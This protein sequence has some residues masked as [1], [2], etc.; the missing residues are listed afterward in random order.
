MSI[1]CSLK[2]LTLTYGHKRIFDSA[3][4]KIEHGEKIGLIGPNGCGKSSLL[5]I[6]SKKV[7]PD[8]ENSSFVFSQ[9]SSNQGRELE[10]SV[11]LIEQSFNNP[12]TPVSISDYFWYSYPEQ[13]LLVEDY[14]Y[15][16]SEKTLSQIENLRIWERQTEYESYLKY[17]GF[18]DLTMTTENLSGGE[19]KKIQLS[20]GL[21]SQSNLILWDEPTNHL[22]IQ[23]I[24]LLE[25]ELIRTKKTILIISHD[26]YLLSKVC[27]KILNI[28]NG[29]I[30][31]YNG[32][33]ADYLEFIGVKEE[34]RLKKLV[35]LKNTLRRE[36]EWM[37]QGIKARGTRSKK[38]VENFDNLSSKVQDLKNQAKKGLELDINKSHQKNKLLISGKNIEMSFGEK[39]LFHPF[40]FE[41]Y[42][43]EKIGLLGDNGVGKSTL[44][45]I[46]SGEIC[47]TNGDLKISDHLKIC[48]F[49]QRKE[50]I[51][52]QK[53]PLEI[54]GQGREFITFE[55]GRST[56]INSYLQNFGFNQDMVNRKCETFSGGEIARLQLAKNL[57]M[58]G[59]IWIFDEPTNDLDIETIEVLEDTLVNF[60]GTIILI[61]HDRSF[62]EN[63]TTQIFNIH[64]QSVDFFSSGLTQVLPYL[65]ALKAEKELTDNVEV[66]KIIQDKSLKKV[67]L[68]YA[69]KKRIE[70]LPK[71]IEQ[72]EKKLTTLEESISNFDYTSLNLEKSEELANLTSMRDQTENVLLELMEEQELLSELS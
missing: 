50:D 38:R 41:I 43:G 72:L 53:T 27:T 48:Y 37:R 45:K 64:D 47:P 62:L 20:L 23:T 21:T 59:D 63:V 36:T 55:N 2:N 57:T 9:A 12:L 6:I 34:E 67:K 8:I 66:P 61:C 33:Y 39:N 46:I 1:I 51:D 54:V 31:E 58:P 14:H 7:C 26:R 4:F 30:E 29:Q 13:K 28:Q 40:D 35:K 18:N 22:D 65:E 19:Q 11:C 32:N 49:S 44:A 17:F 5:K 71:Q 70:E 25:D 3:H 52:Q 68:S 60:Q 15:S 42:R 16:H 56:H 24:E 69:Q 10:F